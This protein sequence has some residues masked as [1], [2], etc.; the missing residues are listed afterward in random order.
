MTLYGCHG[1]GRGVDTLLY[2]GRITS[3]DPQYSTDSARLKRQLDG[4]G[5]GGEW[6]HVHMWL[7]PFMFTRTI[8]MLLTG[9]TSIQNK[10]LPKIKNAV[11]LM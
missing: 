4:R 8:T 9:D 7:R 5:F 10:K 11:C 6:M 2:L 3:E 1:R